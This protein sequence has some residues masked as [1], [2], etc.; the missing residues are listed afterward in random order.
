MSLCHVPSAVILWIV[1]AAH[2]MECWRIHNHIFPATFI[3]MKIISI[4]S[5]C[6][7]RLQSIRLH[8]VGFTIISFLRRFISKMMT[9]IVS[10][11]H[12]ARERCSPVRSLRGAEEDRIGK[13]RMYSERL[14][15]LKSIRPTKLTRHHPALKSG[16]TRR[17]VPGTE[18]RQCL[19][20]GTSDPSGT[21][22]RD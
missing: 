12:T 18:R 21:T 19:P 20:H 14:F 10:R 11:Y 5:H 6:P 4:A 9:S 13:V 2:P 8:G 17:R 3:G 22:S 1:T 15:P 16:P 7:G